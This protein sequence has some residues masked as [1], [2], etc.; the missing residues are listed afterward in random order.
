V[1]CCTAR[2]TLAHTECWPELVEGARAGVRDRCCPKPLIRARPGKSCKAIHGAEFGVGD[3]YHVV[4]SERDIFVASGHL[5]GNGV[6]RLPAIAA[7]PRRG[8]GPIRLPD[9][10]DVTEFRGGLPPHASGPIKVGAGPFAR[11]LSLSLSL[12]CPASFFA[13]PGPRLRLLSASL[14][15]SSSSPPTRL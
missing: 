3:S 14:G 4:R 6:L 5:A 1:T 9:S 12:C 13:Q 2:A 8:S 10:G 11:S 15:S 7:V